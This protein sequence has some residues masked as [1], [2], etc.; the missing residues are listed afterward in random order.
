MKHW[1]ITGG[2]GFIGT[3]LTRLLLEDPA[4]AVRIVD[5]LSVGTRGDLAGVCQF[6]EPGE[7]ALQEWA[8]VQLVPGD[9][10]DE[11][12]ALKL[13]VGADVVVHLA[14]NTGVPGSIEKPRDDMRNNVI[15]TFNYLEA[16]R[17]AGCPRFVFA[18]SGATVGEC[19]PPITED[20]PSRPISPYGASKLAGEGYCSAYSRCF[21]LSAVSLRFGNVYG[22]ASGHKSSVVA[23]FLKN[24]LAGSPLVIHGDGSQTRDFIYID[25]IVSA[26]I[27]AATAEGVGG[28]IFQ[29]ASSREHTIAELAGM[30]ASELTRQGFGPVHMTHSQTRPGDVPRNFS[31]VSKA[32]RMLR[33]QAKY[34]LADGLKETVSW[35]KERCREESGGL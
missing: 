25:D 11:Q 16:A 35:F 30:I 19:T 1:L 18:S 3:S 32:R 9:I 26:V 15:G 20:M 10:L 28:E 22:P 6:V 7:Q 34:E 4:N 5:N 17:R 24:A 13:A 12:L 2:C 33:W 27:A 23:Q 31:D 21:G 14:A 29:I 8:G